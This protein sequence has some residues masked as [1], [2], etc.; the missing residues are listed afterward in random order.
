[1]CPGGAFFVLVSERSEEVV[2]GS[3]FDPGEVQA[4][5]E[6]VAFQQDEG[7]GV[8]G[9]GVGAWRLRRAGGDAPCGVVAG[10]RILV[11]GFVVR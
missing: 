9:L 7:L 8:E 3:D 2:A 11:V 5:G 10:C 4:G 6:Q 1:M